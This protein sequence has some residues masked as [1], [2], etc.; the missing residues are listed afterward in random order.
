[1]RRFVETRLEAR[2]STTPHNDTMPYNGATT[3]IN[4]Q[5]NNLIL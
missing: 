5:Y 3:Y 2:L 4:Q 1:M